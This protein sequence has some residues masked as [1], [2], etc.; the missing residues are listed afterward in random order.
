MSIISDAVL[1]AFRTAKSVTPE[2]VKEII[3]THV[4]EGS[5]YDPSVGSRSSTATTSEPQEGAI[6]YSYETKEVDGDRVRID[7]KKA[8]LI[9]SQLSAEPRKPDYIME[10]SV[11]WNV[12][13]YTEDPTN[14]I[15][16]IQVRRA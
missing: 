4:S 10:G 13:S 11:K 9:Q 2:A 3:Y 7:D 1:T 12:L 15:F 6:F 14:T 5:D 8:I 16:E